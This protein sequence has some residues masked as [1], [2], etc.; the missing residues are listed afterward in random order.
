MLAS[1]IFSAVLAA[2]VEAV[3]AAPAGDDAAL[4]SRIESAWRTQQRWEAVAKNGSFDYDFELKTW[5]GGNRLKEHLERS[6]RVVARNGVTRTEV[7]SSRKDGRDDLAAAREEQAGRE[8]RRERTEG[9]E[10]KTK[11]FPSPFDPKYRGEYAFASAPAGPG[12]TSISFRPRRRLE[13]AIAGTAEFD[14]E[15]RVRRVVF[16]LA[17]PPIFTRNLSF[18]IS[19]DAEGNP[20]RADSSGEI[21]LIVW[22]RRFE[23]SVVVRNVVPRPPEKEI[24]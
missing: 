14:P 24:P 15:G 10:G 13:G 1:L 9:K 8:K 4:A 7:L 20:L 6:L 18:T 17:H 19:L 21:S 5:N 22:K 23:S 2:V 12:R 16:T 11:E 3:P